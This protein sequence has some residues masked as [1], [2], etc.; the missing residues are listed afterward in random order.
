MTNQYHLVAWNKHKR[1]YDAVVLGAVAVFLVVHIGVSLALA[2]APPDPAVL[3]MRALG[4]AA[5]TLLHVVLC[6]GP[7]ARLSEMFLPLLY[8][9]RHL[10][11]TMFLVGLAHA[12]VALFY[13]GLWG[14]QD[15]LHAVFFAGRSFGSIEAFPF[16][17]L[18][19]AG[20]GVLFVMAATSHDFWLV[21]LS[22]RVWKG[23][24]ML[25]YAAYAAV[26]FHAALGGLRDGG[27]TGGLA[28]LALLG[29]GAV[30]VSGLHVASGLREVVRDTAAPRLDEV[31]ADVTGPAPAA[32]TARGAAPAGAQPARLVTDE[33]G[34]WVDLGPVTD[35]PE[36]RARVVCLADRERIAVFRSQGK[37]SA[38]TNVCAHQGGPLGE[39]EIV[40]G[41]IT[42][43]WHGYQYLAHNGQSP[44][45]YSEK[46]ATYRVRIVADRV[47][48]DPRPLP[49]GTPVE[50][51]VF[52][53][54]PD[55]EAL[56]EPVAKA[57]HAPPA[58]PSAAADGRELDVS[59]DDPTTP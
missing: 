35:I 9:R 30:V 44:P 15:P 39:G 53:A 27:G 54:Q 34:V 45:P 21:Q 33:A 16:E 56:F 8:N 3:L 31:A 29:A 5:I 10:G 6:I 23:L 58:G 1:V 12:A 13:Y 48:V 17:L 46:I 40:N 28:G 7:L 11:V 20:L 37:V 19:L 41:C 47:Q 42:C 55:D 36:N 49:P 25:V 43:P 50:P 22:P 4:G 26:V 59:P 32:V 38:V 51:A 18:G 14:T 2:D 57:P 24:H 52:A